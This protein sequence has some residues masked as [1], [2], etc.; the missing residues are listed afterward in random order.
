MRG[1]SLLIKKVRKFCIPNKNK[2]LGLYLYSLAIQ[3]I[4]KLEL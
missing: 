2:H 3:R 4:S 1:I